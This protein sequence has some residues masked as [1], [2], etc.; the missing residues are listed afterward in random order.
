MIAKGRA[1]Y[2]NSAKGE[3]HGMAKITAADAKMIRTLRAAGWLQREIGVKFGISQV[4]VSMI[5]LNKIWVDNLS[6]LR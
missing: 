2:T 5:C 4:T 3:K 1:N 6:A